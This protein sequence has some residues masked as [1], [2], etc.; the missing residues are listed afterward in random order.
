MAFTRR[1]GRSPERAQRGKEAP[2]A[3]AACPRSTRDAD[4]PSWGVLRGECKGGWSGDVVNTTGNHEQV[5]AV[6]RRQRMTSVPFRPAALPTMAAQTRKAVFGI[7]LAGAAPNRPPL[8]HAGQASQSPVRRKL[9]ARRA[10]IVTDKLAPRR[11]GSP[12]PRS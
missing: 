4:D 1:G 7:R 3:R 12:T 9:R 10:K 8:P 5:A 6:P 11:A 2:A